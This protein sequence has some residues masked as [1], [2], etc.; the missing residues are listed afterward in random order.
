MT[1]CKMKNQ[2][3]HTVGKKRQGNR[4]FAFDGEDVADV[5]AERLRYWEKVRL[6]DLWYS[7]QKHTLSDECVWFLDLQLEMIA[8]TIVS[9]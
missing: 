2:P 5:W 1:F 4:R 6:H 8:E 3:G 9:L 7:M